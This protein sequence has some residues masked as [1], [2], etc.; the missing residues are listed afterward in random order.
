VKKKKKRGLI[1]DTIPEKVYS[2]CEEHKYLKYNHQSN[3]GGKV[4]PSLVYHRNIIISVLSSHQPSLLLLI[5]WIHFKIIWLNDKKKL[6]FYWSVWWQYFFSISIHF[7][8]FNFNTKQVALKSIILV[9]KNF[10]LTAMVK[11]INKKCD[12]ISGSSAMVFQVVLR[13]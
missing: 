6:I 2:L 3:R 4:R 8:C 13:W 7:S 11:L 10:V 1:T 5:N 9:K 12:A